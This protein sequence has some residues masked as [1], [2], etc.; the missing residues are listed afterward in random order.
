MTTNI[1]YKDFDFGFDM[2]SNGEL[3]V[4]IDE[5]SIKQSIK[6]IILTGLVEK[7]RYQNSRFGSRVYNFL[8]E[9]ISSLTALQISDE[10][11]NSLNNWESRVKVIEVISEANIQKQLYE[12]LIKYKIKNLNIEDEIVIDL[13]IIK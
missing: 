6:N 9:K 5:D 2:D 4:L 3:S 10:I 7:T 8:G 13:G 12:V 11:E 1:T